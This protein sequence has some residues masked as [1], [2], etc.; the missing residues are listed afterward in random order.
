M[1]ETDPS[2]Q[3]PR[4]PSSASALTIATKAFLG[5]G[6]L[7]ALMAVTILSNG[8]SEPAHTADVM[9]TAAAASSTVPDAP[10]TTI[11]LTTTTLT[12]LQAAQAERGYLVVEAVHRPH[13]DLR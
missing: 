1:T 9:S 12:P 8:S 3:T 13:Q 10:L 2:P 6:L 4:K 7:L 11:S 5:V